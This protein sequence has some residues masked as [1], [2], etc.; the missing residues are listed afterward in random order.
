MEKWKLIVASFLERNLVLVIRWAML[1]DSVAIPSLFMGIFFSLIYLTGECA[2]L[3]AHMFVWIL[4]VT[5]GSIESH[6][7]T[8][9]F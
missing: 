4:S 3:T 5:E 7:V 8:S 1:M 9:V 2:A 6:D